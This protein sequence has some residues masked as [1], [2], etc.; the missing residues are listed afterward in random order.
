VR[1]CPPA[2]S[3]RIRPISI[4]VD[5]H[6]VFRGIRRSRSP[7]SDDPARAGDP[8]ISESEVGR[9][10]RAGDPPISESE[11]G[12][13]GRER[14]WFSTAFVFGRSQ[15]PGTVRSG[16]VRDGDGTIVRVA[17]IL[18]LSSVDNPRYD[19]GQPVVVPRVPVG[20]IDSAGVAATRAPRLGK[21]IRRDER[22]LLAR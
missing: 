13:P 3:P 17:G 18:P 7:K 6:L 22:S 8:P 19:A 1:A 10:G 15:R 21:R 4:A 9:P 20:A 11:I 16:A 2:G 5:N 12:R 14:Q